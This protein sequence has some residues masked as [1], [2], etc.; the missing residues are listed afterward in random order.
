MVSRKS[1][2]DAFKF[3]RDWEET[4]EHYG[5]TVEEIKTE[6]QTIGLKSIRTTYIK[7]DKVNVGDKSLF[8]SVEENEILHEQEQVEETIT[9][10]KK[11]VLTS[12]RSIRHKI[13]F[14]GQIVSID[15]LEKWIDQNKFDPNNESKEVFVI[16]SKLGDG[17]K[18]NPLIIVFSSHTCLKYLKEQFE[19]NIPQFGMDC[20]SKVNEL[21]Y[22]LA[23]LVTQDASHTTFP[24]SFAICSSECQATHSFILESLLNSYEHIY[25]KKFAYKYIMSNAA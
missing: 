21:D 3:K 17:S 24:I 22:P 19:T 9:K 23:C 15:D 12:I 13:Q 11:K 6:F 7:E 4:K 14:K 25:K 1:Q 16:G 10:E 18:T 20:I 2:N 5:N 8:I